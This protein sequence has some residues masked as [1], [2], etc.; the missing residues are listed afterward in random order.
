MSN[1]VVDLG[2]SE[3]ASV[4]VW[5]SR[6]VEELVQFFVDLAWERYILAYVLQLGAN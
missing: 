1:S 5:G 2:L 3:V 4:P 6:F